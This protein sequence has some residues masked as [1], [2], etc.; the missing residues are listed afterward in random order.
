MEHAKLISKTQ[1]LTCKNH[2]MRLKWNMDKNMQNRI[3]WRTKAGGVSPTE[4]TGVITTHY[5]M[6]LYQS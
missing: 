3:P 2:E 1:G 4:H 6:Y 5:E